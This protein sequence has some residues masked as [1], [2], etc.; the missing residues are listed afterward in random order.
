MIRFKNSQEPWTLLGSGTPIA[1]LFLAVR[2]NG[3]CGFA[4]GS[5]FNVYAGA[6][7]IE[8]SLATR[9]A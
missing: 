1:C 3:E 4:R 8:A 9:P 5:G 7:R 2:I 6:E